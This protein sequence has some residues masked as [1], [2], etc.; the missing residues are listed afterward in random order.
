MR[1]IVVALTSAVLLQLVL[2]PARH[3]HGGSFIEEL[4]GP[5]RFYGWDIQ[6][7]V[8]CRVDGSPTG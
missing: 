8:F 3:P 4:S 2:L 7:R 6:M 5:G 1:R